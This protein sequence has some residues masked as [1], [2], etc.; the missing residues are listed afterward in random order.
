MTNSIEA[1]GE[2][3][4][5]AVFVPRPNCQTVMEI[6]DL[7][8][9]LVGLQEGRW[10]WCKNSRCKYVTIGIDTRSGAYSLRDRDGNAITPAQLNWQIGDHIGEQ[11]D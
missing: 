5:V 2:R 11:H 8:E 10:S 9:W 7:I 3:E 6:P 4:A 1:P